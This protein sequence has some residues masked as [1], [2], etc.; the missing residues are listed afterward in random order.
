MPSTSSGEEME[1][2]LPMEV[3]ARLVTHEDDMNETLHQYAVTIK[4]PDGLY[5]EVRSSPGLEDQAAVKLLRRLDKFALRITAKD[6]CQFRKRFLLAAASG[7]DLLMY[8]MCDCTAEMIFRQFTS[9]MEN[10]IDFEYQNFSGQTQWSIPHTPTSPVCEHVIL[11]MTSPGKVFAESSIPLH[12]SLFSYN[13]QGQRVDSQSRELRAV[14]QRYTFG[15][16]LKDVNCYPPSATRTKD[17]KEKLRS[18]SFIIPVSETLFREIRVHN[19]RVFPANEHIDDY[20]EYVE[21]QIDRRIIRKPE[22]T[23]VWSA[24]KLNLRDEIIL[25]LYSMFKLGE[26][27]V[28]FLE[29]KNF[30]RNYDWAQPKELHHFAKYFTSVLQM[31]D[32]ELNKKCVMHSVPYPSADSTLFRTTISTEEPSQGA[33]SC[34]GCPVMT[35]RESERVDR[36][37]KPSEKL[38]YFEGEVMTMEEYS[39]NQQ[40]IIDLFAPVESINNSPQ[41][42]TNNT[43]A[44][45]PPQAKKKKTQEFQGSTSNQTGSSTQ[46]GQSSSS[47]CPAEVQI[48]VPVNSIGQDGRITTQALAAAQEALPEQATPPVAPVVQPVPEIPQDQVDI[49]P[50]RPAAAHENL[51]RAITE[52]QDGGI[53]TQSVAAAQEAPS[54]QS[55]PPTAPMAH[56]IPQIPSLFNNIRP[57]M[58]QPAPLLRSTEE[59]RRSTVQAF[60]ATMEALSAQ[61]ILP[62]SPVTQS[63]PQIP[64]PLNSSRPAMV[65]PAPLLRSTEEDRR[66]TVQ[67][68]AAAIEALSAQRTI[69]ASPVAQSM[70]QIPSPLNS[71]RPAMVQPAPLDST[72]EGRRA[73]LQALAAALEGLLAHMPL[74]TAPVAHP[75]LHFPSPWN[76]NLEQRNNDTVSRMDQ[77]FSAWQRSGLLLPHAQVDNNPPRPPAVRENQQPATTRNQAGSLRQDGRTALQSLIAALEGVSARTTPPVRRPI[78]Q[79]PSLFY[80][81]LE[82]RSDQSARRTQERVP[83]WQLTGVSPPA[84]TQ[85]SPSSPAAMDESAGLALFAAAHNNIRAAKARALRNALQNLN[86]NGDENVRAASDE[87]WVVLDPGNRDLLSTG[88]QL[89]DMDVDFPS[90]SSSSTSSIT[91]GVDNEVSGQQ[92]PA[93]RS[94]E[95]IRAEERRRNEQKRRQRNRRERI[96]QEME[97]SRRNQN[98]QRP[99]PRRNQAIELSTNDESGNAPSDSTAPN[100]DRNGRIDQLNMENEERI[101]EPEVQILEEAD[102][103]WSAAEIPHPAQNVNEEHALDFERL[104]LYAEMRLYLELRVPQFA[105]HSEIREQYTD[106]SSE[107]NDASRSQYEVCTLFTFLEHST[108]GI[109]R[110]CEK[111]FAHKAKSLLSEDQATSQVLSQMANS[112]AAIKCNEILTFID[113]ENMSRRTLITGL[114]FVDSKCRNLLVNHPLRDCYITIRDRLIAQGIRQKVHFTIIRAFFEGTTA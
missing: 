79:I 10:L 6:F 58:V 1:E 88:E 32:D 27:S 83:I 81:S 113:I 22:L 62:S 80:G 29:E 20:R 25:S 51:A 74:S 102:I 33:A 108:D 98:Q 69:P 85:I 77:V 93:P 28:K 114:D 95:E 49:T 14:Q 15:G 12:D 38:I 73:A 8:N 66:S 16:P 110:L 103:W 40:R 94:Q 70:P 9:S 78:P 63:M 76:G 17:M 37:K 90:D 106:W 42:P 56:P 11:K 45:D 7:Y 47:T 57:A 55:T 21:E 23:D 52:N 99:T 26:K 105:F 43:T 4:T 65:Q 109:H 75:I 3:L 35:V 59:D 60:A 54:A 19:S 36:H 96:R 89:E 41:Q 50:P 18:F 68:F 67:A 100:D 72:G 61:R 91:I 111:Y 86:L 13:S 2:R 82:Q 97:V 101:I 39:A 30:E 87:E 34:K 107:F 24:I 53:A 71:S 104:E 84:Q 64:S 31:P 44:S 48:S 46:D 112:F 92:G 5:K